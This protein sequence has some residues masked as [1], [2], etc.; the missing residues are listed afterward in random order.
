MSVAGALGQWVGIEEPRLP[1]V[2]VRHGKQGAGPVANH[3]PAGLFGARLVQPQ[4]ETERERE[5]ERGWVQYLIIGL[6][7]N[8]SLTHL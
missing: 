7:C 1:D 3:C 8:M 6:C 2:V 4:G 5:S